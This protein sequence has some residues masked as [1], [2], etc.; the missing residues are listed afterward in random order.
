MKFIEEYK[1]KNFNKNNLEIIKKENSSIIISNLENK[2]INS[3]L[4]KN[5]K[6]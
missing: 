4:N 3:N 5:E 6:K 1:H 2:K